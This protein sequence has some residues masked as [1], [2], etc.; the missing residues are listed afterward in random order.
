MT[1]QVSTQIKGTVPYVNLLAYRGYSR[2]EKVK[3]P[4]ISDA[5]TFIW[6]YCV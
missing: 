5:I 6:S 3:L 1:I 4:V 2:Y